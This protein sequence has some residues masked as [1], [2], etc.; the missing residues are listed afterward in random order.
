MATTSSTGSL[1]SPGVGSGLDVVGIV[2]K[3]MSVEKRPLVLLDAQIK[4]DQAEISAYGTLRSALA[5]L[6]SSLAGLRDVSAFKTLAA[7]ISDT[8]LL[9]ATAGSGAVAGSYNVQVTA[10]AKAQ[11]LAST[12]FASA[13]DTV[14]SGS[15]TFDFGTVVGAVFTSNGNGAKTVTIGAGQGTLAGIRD[16]V[17]AANIGVTATIVS[18]GGTNGTHLVFTA[19]SGAA[20]SLKITVS[21]GDGTA[22]DTAGLSQLAYD[23][24]AAAGSG[25]NMEQKVEAQDATLIVD[26]ITIKRPT[27]TVTDAI[28]GVTLNLLKDGAPAATLTVAANPGNTGA[29]ISGFVTAYNQ[30]TSTLASLTK[31]DA[32]QKQAS[33]LTGDATVRSI[34]QQLRSILTSALPSGAYTTLSQAG[35]QFKADG[36]L[37][38]DSAKLDT[39]L[40]ANPAGI[41]QLFAAVGTATDALASVSGFSSK[42]AVGTYA[43]SITQ[44]AR[45]ASLAGSAAAG[46]TITTGVNDTLSVTVDGIAATVTLAAG[47][48]ASADAL[49]AEVRAKINGASAFTQAGS[50][51]SITQAAGVLTIASARYG[52]ASGVAFSGNAAET[53][54]GAAPVATAGL[55][56]AG[57]IGGVAATGSG[58]T[59][60]GASGS[61]TEGLRI[62]IAGG[63]LGDRGSVTFGQGFAYRLN[64]LI[65][66]VTD[67]EGTI[68]ARTDGLQ[69][70]IEQIRKREEAINQRLAK[71]EE[72][73]TR[74]FNRLDTLLATLNTQSTF[75]AQQLELLRKNTSES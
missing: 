39:A 8:S 72:N 9:T 22:T 26:G 41:T 69:K 34:Q 46:L 49:A 63:A 31:Y 1:A 19:A 14:G 58:Q 21:D 70:S 54:V 50:K 48:Y 67:K 10:L 20:N 59:L 17:N 15:L 35:V 61:P 42:T 56:V 7:T 73:Y 71:V 4:T 25:K 44:L 11:K 52:S 68:S 30:L 74:Q 38:L 53:L 32:A 23:P 2:N 66:R 40:K 75:L 64:E 3:L 29:M 65:T 62:D 5:A 24:A 43:L 45:Q 33:V 13:N 18:D 27:N 60:V 51:V 6:Q 28:Q 57:S 36:T 12:G 16:A 37:A 47:I 55:D